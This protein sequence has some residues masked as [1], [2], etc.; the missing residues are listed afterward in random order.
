[1]RISIVILTY[2]QRDT[3][4]RCLESLKVCMSKSDC[5]IILVDNGSSDDICKVV[6]RLYPDVRL[7][8]FDRNLGVSVGRNAGLKN[9][10]GQ[11]LMILDNDTIASESAIGFLSHYLEQHPEVGIVAPKLTD[12]FGT[13]QNSFKPYPSIGVKLYNILV[14]INRT[15]KAV[16][17]PT[18]PIEPF[19]VIGAAQMFSREVYEAVGGFDEKIFYGPE[20]ADFCMAVRACGKKV[21]YNP[22]VTIVHDWQRRTTGNLVSS[23][24]WKHISALWYFYR[25]HRRWI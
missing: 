14:G 11:Y 20:D 2:N 21:V 3:T 8:H 1:M 18:E 23:I 15:S 7:L 22:A 12:I 25:K 9:S 10:H 24:A 19:Y 16:T 5:E 6:S 17:V 4:L 13:V